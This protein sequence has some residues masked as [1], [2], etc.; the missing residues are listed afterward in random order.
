M[1]DKHKHD[2]PLLIMIEISLTLTP[3]PNIIIIKSSIDLE[4][5]NPLYLNVCSQWHLKMK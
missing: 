5:I 3:N 2:I 1:A 4:Q